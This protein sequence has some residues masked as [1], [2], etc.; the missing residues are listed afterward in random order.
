MTPALTG[1][2]RYG[3]DAT[4][5]WRDRD[6]AR[7]DDAELRSAYSRGGTGY[8]RSSRAP[9]GLMLALLVSLGITVAVYAVGRYPRGHPLLPEVAFSLP[10]FDHTYLTT[11]TTSAA[12]FG[13]TF[14]ISGETH[15]RQN[16]PVQA[17]GS[18]NGQPWQT[19]A[20]TTTV[21]GIYRV[22]FPITDHG[23]LKV[24]IRYSGGQAD[25]D[26]LVP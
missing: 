26:I 1:H 9:R 14:A 10:G 3:E 4:V 24:R 17:D 12:E 19:L 8:G 7:L 11:M 20:T 13:S 23:T 21:N 16:G 5:G 6:W 22:Q 25:G 15:D 2:A 18:W